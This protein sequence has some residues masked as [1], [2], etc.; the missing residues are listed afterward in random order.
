MSEARRDFR[1]LELNVCTH[2]VSECAAASKCVG[3]N[4]V[5]FLNLLFFFNSINNFRP[6]LLC[7]QSRNFI[8]NIFL[9]FLCKQIKIELR[10]S[11]CKFQIL[12]VATSKVV[13]I[14]L[15]FGYGNPD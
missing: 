7:M 2:N 12:S 8:I 5:H 11:T 6:G 10:V 13:V 14:K 15:Y 4:I 1:I 3:F 9:S